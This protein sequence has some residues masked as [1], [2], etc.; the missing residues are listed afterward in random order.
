MIPRSPSKMRKIDIDVAEAEVMKIF[1]PWR[2]LIGTFETNFTEYLKLK[3]QNI[4][5]S[6]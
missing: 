1:S 5:K 6:R 2:L 4:K 3:I